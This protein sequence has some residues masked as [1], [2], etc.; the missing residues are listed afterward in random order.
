M[1]SFVSTTSKVWKATAK[2][3]KAARIHLLR[4]LSTRAPLALFV[5]CHDN[6]SYT[7]VTLRPVS[8]RY[9]PFYAAI[10]VFLL[11]Y[12]VMSSIVLVFRVI[13]APVIA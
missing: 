8:R 4:S 3:E 9:E 2:S 1:L 12:I 11:S 5:S 13:T 10:V 7:A 6:V